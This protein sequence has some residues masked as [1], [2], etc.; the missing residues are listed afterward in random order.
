MVQDKI[1]MSQP[2]YITG[3]IS[4]YEEVE[5]AY[6]IGLGGRRS[7]SGCSSAKNVESGNNASPKESAAATNS[8][9]P[10]TPEKLTWFADA[11]FWNPP[12]PWSTDPNTVE[13][14][15]TQK[16]GLTFEFNIPAQDGGTKLNLMLATSQE[17]PDIIT[18]TDSQ[19]HKKLVDSGKIWDLDE[20][21]QKYNPSSPLI[22]VFPGG[23][24]ES[25]NQKVWR[26]RCNSKPYKL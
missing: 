25:D 7:S 15:I 26:F 3:V 23:C 16:T 6:S 19:L 22:D 9:E 18:I 24:K 4:K 14:A 11:S 8:E 13:G 17:L 1:R 5:N 2:T 12:A 20:F 10:V 21:M